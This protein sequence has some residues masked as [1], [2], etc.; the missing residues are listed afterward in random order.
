MPGVTARGWRLCDERSRVAL[1]QDTACVYVGIPERA[2]SGRPGRREEALEQG[3][4]EFGDGDAGLVP[5]SFGSAGE[6]G[7]SVA[8]AQVRGTY[9]PWP[10]S[11][12]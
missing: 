5:D 9:V 10:G 6:A 2:V 12:P 11:P 7:C 3:R 8:V 1:C 4:V